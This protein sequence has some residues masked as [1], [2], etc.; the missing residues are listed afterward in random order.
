[1][2]VRLDP[3]RWI[4]SPNCV[5]AAGEHPPVT[6]NGGKNSTHVQTIVIGKNAMPK[7]ALNISSAG[8]KGDK[9]E[10]GTSVSQVP[11]VVYLAGLSHRIIVII[12]LGIIHG[13]IRKERNITSLGYTHQCIVRKRKEY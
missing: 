10:M 8:L 1:M 13:G 2:L 3:D 5:L 4:S 9:G 11:T 6:I 7:L 12:N